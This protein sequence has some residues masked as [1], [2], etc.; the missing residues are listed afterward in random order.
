MCNPVKKRVWLRQNNKSREMIEKF[1]LI[2]GLTALANYSMLNQPVIPVYAMDIKA[3]KK[4]GAIQEVSSE[5]EAD[6]QLEL[7]SYNPK[8]FA[9]DGLVD[10]FSL[11]L[12]LQDVKDER[13]E[14]ALEKLI[15]KETC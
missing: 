8:L 14:A 3:W 12:S 11:Y 15:E 4:T 7:W 13:V 9:Q 2:S 1:G 10:P 5:E 6:A